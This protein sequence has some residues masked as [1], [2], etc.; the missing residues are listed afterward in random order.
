MQLRIGVDR[1]VSQLDEAISD[2]RYCL[3]TVSEYI[4]KN[5]VNQWAGCCVKYY[6]SID[7]TNDEAKRLGKNGEKH[8]TLVIAEEQR[9]GKGRLGR[10]WDSPKGKAIY[11]T[12]LLR[13]QIEPEK[14]SFLTL[15]A[16]L[17]VTD[18]IMQVTGVSVQIKWP[19][20]I[21]ANGRKLCGILTEMST[22][23]NGIRYVVVGIGINCNMDSFPQQLE[24]TATSLFLETG[25]KQSRV[26]LIAS[27]MQ[28]MEQYY[29]IF[30]QT[31]DFKNLKPIYEKWL[32]NYNRMVRVLSPNGEYIGT[33]RGI[34]EKGELLVVD[35]AGQ[36]HTVRS[37]EVSVRGIYGYTI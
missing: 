6:D 27:V 18:A 17:A 15:L 25:K 37:G 7:S 5:T 24:S 12:L 13:P 11:M 16:A 30:M 34:N 33:S 2:Q 20:D 31:G 26:Q 36:L 1:K 8:G 32:V 29:E 22:D 14:A 3:K 23:A 19:N 21:V 35:E 4:K 28:S 10:S 9:L